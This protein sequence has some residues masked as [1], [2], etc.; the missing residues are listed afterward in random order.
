MQ[1]AVRSAAAAGILREGPHRIVTAVSELC[2]NSDFIGTAHGTALRVAAK[3][4]NS[5]K[6]ASVNINRVVLTGNLT[7]D[8]DLRATQSGLNVCSLRLAVNTRRKNN[9]TSK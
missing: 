5:S 8:P 7:K 3:L 1:A 9:Q 2:G 6:G 4:S